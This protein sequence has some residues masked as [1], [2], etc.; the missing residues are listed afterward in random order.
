M[1]RG[2]AES[3]SLN[4]VS[5]YLF[6]SKDWVVAAE[7]LRDE[8]A[9]RL[10]ESPIATK[11][12]VI[13]TDLPEQ[14][15]FPNAA[16]LDGQPVIQ[17]HVNTHSG[18]LLMEQGHLDDPEITITTDYATA[19]AAFV[20]QDQQELMNAFI[21]GKI[22]VDGDASKLLALQAPPTDPEAAKLAGEVYTKLRGFTKL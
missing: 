1:T 12:N 21:G 5:T 20:T 7:N 15:D 2:G 11:L 4:V 22:L 9:G 16:E 13:V 3:A 19:L 14:V 17:G 10:P 8:Y 6:L 18:Q